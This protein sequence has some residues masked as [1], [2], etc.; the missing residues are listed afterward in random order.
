MSNNSA[1][2][3]RQVIAMFANP[4]TRQIIAKMMLGENFEQATAEMKANRQ[5]N[6][7]GRLERLGLV[8]ENGE[9]QADLFR[10][11]LDQDP[12][13]KKVGIEKFI[14]DDGRISSY[15]MNAD[16][17]IELLEWVAKQVLQPGEVIAEKEMNQRL[18]RFHNDF[19]TLR[20][21]M[22]DYEIMERTS[23]GTEYALVT[24]PAS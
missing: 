3:W 8:G 7:K 19:S 14:T 10:N 11:I 18:L 20:R 6:L 21:Y 24:D 13:Q 16:L 5:A 22:I 1:L 9:F 23:T 2:D 4:E 12:V 17:R 15:P